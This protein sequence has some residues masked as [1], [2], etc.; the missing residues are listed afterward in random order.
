MQAVFVLFIP[1][2]NLMEIS[3]MLQGCP[4]NSDTDLLKHK[5]VTILL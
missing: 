2:D 5:A 3:N 4:N 1:V